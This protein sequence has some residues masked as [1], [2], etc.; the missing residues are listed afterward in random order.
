MYRQLVEPIADDLG[1]DA[2][3]DGVRR[4]VLRNDRAR[5]DNG[6]VADLDAID[7]RCAD[8]D[9]DVVPDERRRFVFERA[10]LDG[11]RPFDVSLEILQGRRAKPV[12]R[13]LKHSDVHPIG[14]RAITAHLH[15]SDISLETGVRENRVSP[16]AKMRFQVDGTGNRTGSFQNHVRPETL[17]PARQENPPFF[18]QPRIDDAT[19][20]HPLPSTPD[21]PCVA[22][23]AGSLLGPPYAALDHFRRVSG[24]YALRLRNH[25]PGHDRTSSDHAPVGNGHI[26]QY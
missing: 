5:R 3:D 11:A 10:R 22:Q 18:R 14:N 15:I 2:A 7:Q 21:R 25:A 19:H 17:P 23:T 4:Y 26:F 20:D 12:G 16:Y 1:G 9:P 13:M 24:D 6:P 8:A